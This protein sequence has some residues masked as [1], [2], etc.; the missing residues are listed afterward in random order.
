VTD[1]AGYPVIRI[2]GLSDFS[3]FRIFRRANGAEDWIMALEARRAAAAQASADFNVVAPGPGPNQVYVLARDSGRDLAALYLYDTSTGALGA[4]LFTPQQA[5]AATPWLNPTTRALIAG[6]EFAHRLTCRAGDASMQSQLNAVEGFFRREATVRVIDMSEDL[7]RWLLEVSGPTE[8][9]GFYLYD[10]TAG[11]VSPVA[12]MHPNVD[13]AAL[14]PTQVVTY[15]ASDGA[16]LWA[17][18][19]ARPG[20]SGPRPMIVLPHGGP[21]ARDLYGYDAFAQFLASRG[22]VVVQPNFRGSAGFGR[23]FA[24]AGRGQWGRRMQDDL[25][26][27]VR[28]MIASGAADAARVC[29]VGASYGGY[30][31]LAGAALTPDLYRCAVSI[32]GVSDLPELVYRTSS[33]GTAARHYLIRSIG[34]PG[35]DRAALD[36]I[37]PRHLADRIR[38]PVLL[39]HG[40]ED[41][42]VEIRQSELMQQA[43]G[44][45]SRLVRVPEEGH[46]WD[47]WSRE[48]RLAMFREVEQFL[49]EHNPAR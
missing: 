43:L 26:D 2:D 25:T 33:S 38:A 14:S 31:A 30:A 23:A 11:R 21:E 48:H 19:T 17:Y 28:H 18:V 29:I 15:A 37:S 9:G 6:C 49:A 32:A 22:Y 44:R 47:E 12:D 40:E 10:R 24:D 39:I 34:D 41:D 5:D 13:A 1:G 20:S 8:A 46:I 4:P 7:N 45:R 16:Q 35:A 42:V 36:A 3:G 27:A